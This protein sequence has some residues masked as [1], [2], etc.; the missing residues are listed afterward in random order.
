MPEEERKTED[1][2]PPTYEETPTVTPRNGAC[3]GKHQQ[4]RSGLCTRFPA[5]WITVVRTRC[6]AQQYYMYENGNKIGISWAASKPPHPHTAQSEV[7]APFLLKSE[8]SPCMRTDL[9]SYSL[10]SPSVIGYTL[11]PAPLE[12]ETLTAV[13][14]TWAAAHL[15]AI[16]IPDGRCEL[17]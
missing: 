3:R 8:R 16:G 17:P 9:D 10:C 2:V 4:L 5:T 12:M 1:E 13:A 7:A 14:A 15:Q 6:S 11:R